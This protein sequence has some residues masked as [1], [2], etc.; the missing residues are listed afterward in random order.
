MY[1]PINSI[2]HSFKA[3]ISGTSDRNSLLPT[4]YYLLVD[5]LQY[6]LFF[7]AE[8]VVCSG[9]HCIQLKAYI[10]HLHLLLERQ[11]VR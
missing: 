11:L 4:Q 6:L 1:K 10:S 9:Q 8:Q 3:Y 5:L 7:F 2:S